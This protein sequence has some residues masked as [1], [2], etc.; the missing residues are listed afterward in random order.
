MRDKLDFNFLYNLSF[1]RITNKIP[2]Y[3][4]EL[5]YIF[6]T[7]SNKEQSFIDLGC[8]YGHYYEIYK[9]YFKKIY[10][11]DLIDIRGEKVKSYPFIKVN[12]NRKQIF[13]QKFD[14]ILCLEV[15]EHIENENILFS[16]LREITSDNGYLIISTPNINRVFNIVTFKRFL[17]KE[18]CREYALKELCEKFENCGFKILRKGIFI[19]RIGAY[20]FFCDIPEYLKQNIILL[21]QKNK[22][23]VHGLKNNFQSP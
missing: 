23:T 18:H 7:F 20:T 9:S 10:F 13:K 6:S 19:N 2:D 21:A 17:P 3:I 8:S 15:I 11:S 12:L 22:V 4:K 1:E 14:F 16:N 5:R